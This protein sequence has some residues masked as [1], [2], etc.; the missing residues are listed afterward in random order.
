MKLITLPHAGGFGNFY[1]PLKALE[2]E[3]LSVINYEYPGHGSRFRET[4]FT[5]ADSAV[6]LVYDELFNDDEDV[7]LFGHSMGAFLA[8]ELAVELQENGREDI[9]SGIIVSAALPCSYYKPCGVDLKSIDAVKAYLE[10]LGGTASA[11]TQNK[12]FMEL[13]LKVV[14]ADLGLFDTYHFHLP[15]EPF[16][17][18]LRV[19]YAEDDKYINPISAMSEWSAFSENYLGAAIYKGGH[20]YIS[21]QWESVVSEVGKVIKMAEKCKERA[22]R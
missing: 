5:D 10:E 6:K 8:E 11:V 17:C 20:F 13:Y 22:V 16:R 4:L 1:R 18:F 2:S 14:T 15:D 3:S 19:L 9:L 21:D 12:S 7:I